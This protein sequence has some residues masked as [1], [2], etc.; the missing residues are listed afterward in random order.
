MIQEYLPV[1]IP[2]FLAFLT[3]E[4]VGNV[5]SLLILPLIMGL[6]VALELLAALN[7]MGLSWAAAGKVLWQQW[8]R[9][10]DID[11]CMVYRYRLR[12]L[13]GRSD[14]AQE[15]LPC[16]STHWTIIAHRHMHQ[17]VDSVFLPGVPTVK[18]CADA[19]RSIRSRTDLPISRIVIVQHQKGKTTVGSLY[20]PWATWDYNQDPRAY[21]KKDHATQRIYTEVGFE[22]TARPYRE[23]AL[24]SWS[25]LGK[26]CT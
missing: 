20:V 10:N 13:R 1:V 2:V 9:W 24:D 22:R 16:S 25:A 14:V 19:L 6:A 3:A 21:L 4:F 11:T 15:L 17:I 12:H 8:Y 26:H 5:A 7:A 23:P 18:S